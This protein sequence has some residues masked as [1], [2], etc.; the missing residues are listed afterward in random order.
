MISP[1]CHEALY[2]DIIFKFQKGEKA[3]ALNQLA[4]LIRRNRDYYIISLIDPELAGFSD[5][6]QPMLK[7]IFEQAGEKARQIIPDSKEALSQLV[8]IL[9][10][11][12]KIVFEAKSLFS[13]IENL[14]TA[15]SYFGYLDII[16]YGESIVNM[17][18]KSIEVRNRN[19]SKIRN[20]LND[21]LKGC[22]SHIKMLNYPSMT[23]PIERQVMLI[24]KKMEK[25]RDVVGNYDAEKYNA[26]LKNLEMLSSESI[27]IRQKLERLEGTILMIRFFAKFL[28]KSVIIQVVNLA[29]SL[30]LMPIAVHYLS[31]A[32]PSLEISPHNI[33]NYQKIVLAFGGISG[34][35]LASILTSMDPASR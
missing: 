19:L 27:R 2:L 30:F 35:I 11:Q 20:D 32:I 31:F 29:I 14:L 22:E 1:Y 6:I 12:D 23:R 18:E 34:L 7:Q 28:K 10:E 9:G 17:G 5:A 8:S 15:D 21:R 33:W 13:M 16:H 25:D 26:I 24:K 4:K 3:F